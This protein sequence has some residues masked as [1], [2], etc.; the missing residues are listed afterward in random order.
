MPWQYLGETEVKE[1]FEAIG[2]FN[3]STVFRLSS[4]DYSSRDER[5]RTFCY[6]KMVYLGGVDV[7]ETKWQRVYPGVTPVIIEIPRPTELEQDGFVSRR[8]LIKQAS[9]RY[10]GTLQSWGVKIENYT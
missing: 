7:G 5:Y 6:V 8:L 9:L 2:N 4:T 1:E 3:A 10:P